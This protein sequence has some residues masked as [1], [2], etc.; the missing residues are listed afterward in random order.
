MRRPPVITLN[1]HLYSFN[2]ASGQKMKKRNE[3]KNE[4]QKEKEKK[5]FVI[6]QLSKWA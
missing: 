5:V 4:Y 3:E 1:S 6:S 2:S